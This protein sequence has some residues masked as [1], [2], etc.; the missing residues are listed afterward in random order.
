MRRF[1]FLVLVMAAAALPARAADLDAAKK[2]FVRFCAK[3][4]GPGGKG[5]GPQADAL[6][7]KP[8]DFTDCARMKAI[9]DDTLFTAIKEGGAA[10]KLSKDMPPWKDGM[11]DAEIHDLVAYV[12][13]LCT[14]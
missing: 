5:D 12:R 13:T 8:R 7:P 9:T 1:G 3:C 2:D 10:V 4:H 6:D 11:E 14:K